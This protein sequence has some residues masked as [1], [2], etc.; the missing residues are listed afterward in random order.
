MNFSGY[1]KHIYCVL[2]SNYLRRNIMTSIKRSILS[3]VIVSFIFLFSACNKPVAPL[4]G[5]KNSSK[6]SMKVSAL[7]G[8][9]GMGM[10]K[11]IK[12]NEEGKSAL[13]YDFNLVGSP[14]ELVGKI[15]NGEVDVAAVPINLAMVLYNSTGGKVQLAAV[16]TLGVLYILENGNS[17]EKFEDLKGKKVNVSGKGSMPEYILEY[18]LS[19]NNLAIDKDVEV[20]F[21]LQHADLAA[22]VAAGDIDVALLP[23]P[24]VSTAMMKNENVNIA[25]DINE[26]WKKAFNNEGELY[27][28]AIIV[29][30]EFAQNNKNTLDT[31]LDEYKASVD[32]VN[33]NLDEAS[34]LIANNKILP[35]KEIAKK[36]IPYSNIV[37]IDAKDVKESVNNISLGYKH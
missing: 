7:N 26:E 3:M 30:K 12:D 27:M 33:N 35:N 10:V 17:I 1:L 13:N 14:D 23:Q 25:L 15:V 4:E 29:Q 19:K 9:T 2:H 6:S 18:L 22:A 24:H 8:P 28:G 32:F 37:Y 16:N 5:D 21:K 11:L 31:F 36:A 34:E 20:D